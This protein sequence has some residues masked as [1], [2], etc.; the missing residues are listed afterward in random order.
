MSIKKIT[1][2]QLNGQETK[3]QLGGQQDGARWPKWLEREFTDWKVRGSDKTS[4]SR[5]PLCR[6]GLPGSIPTLMQPSGSVAVR[7]RKGATAE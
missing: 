6:L 4:A 3:R 1:I 2:H 5:L 7:H